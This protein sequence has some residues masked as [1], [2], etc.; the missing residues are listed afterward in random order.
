VLKRALG[1][2][3]SNTDYPPHDLTRW[4]AESL[5]SLL[6]RQFGTVR[7]GSLPYYFAHPAGRALANPLHLLSGARMGQSLWA[8]AKNVLCHAAVS[9]AR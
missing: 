2:P 4:S 6:R 8:C 1:Q 3:H 9:A 5:R 7:V